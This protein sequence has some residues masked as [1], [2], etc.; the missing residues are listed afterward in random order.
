LRCNRTASAPVTAT[1]TN[2]ISPPTVTL[3]AP[4]A[5]STVSGTTTVS[6]TASDN[7]RVVGVQFLL[8]G[9]SLGAEVT[10]SP[11]SLA[12]NTI[13]TVSGAHTLTAVA[14][15]PAGNRT[16]SATV[17]VTVANDTSPPTVTL[18]APTPASA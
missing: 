11:Y 15:D 7:V 16:T 2:D 14:R 4:A 6:A 18:T 5:G 9:T 3:T 17:T 8:D 10:A 12:W 13:T 1:V